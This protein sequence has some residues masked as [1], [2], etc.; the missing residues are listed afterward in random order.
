MFLSKFLD[1]LWSYISLTYS[2]VGCLHYKFNTTRIFLR[3]VFLTIQSNIQSKLLQN[4]SIIFCKAPI[5]LPIPDIHYTFSSSPLFL[6]LLYFKTLSRLYTSAYIFNIY[7]NKFCNGLKLWSNS[8]LLFGRCLNAIS[9]WH[10]TPITFIFRITTVFF[11][12]RL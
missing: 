2:F 7:S 10:L 6:W 5:F 4:S 11:I 12:I 8:L 1:Y 3:C 9:D